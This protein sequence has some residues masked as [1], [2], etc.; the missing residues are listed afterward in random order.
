MREIL[1]RGITRD[2]KIIVTGFYFYSEAENKHYITGDSKDYRFKK[3]EVI[4]ETI[5]QF[6]GLTLDGIKLFE[7]DLFKLTFSDGSTVTKV[8]RYIQNKCQF[9]VA[10]INDLENEQY[11][12]IWSGITKEWLDKIVNKYEAIGNIHENSELLNA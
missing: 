2:L 10:N 9:C 7:G 5:G 3:M 1:F 4:P 12:D 8:I 11:W 6:T